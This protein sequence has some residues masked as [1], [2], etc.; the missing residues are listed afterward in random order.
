MQERRAEHREGCALQRVENTT[1]NYTMGS[2]CSLEMQYVGGLAA[3]SCFR[4]N[5]RNILLDSAPKFGHTLAGV[6]RRLCVRLAS[7]TEKSDGAIILIRNKCITSAS[8]L[9]LGTSPPHCVTTLCRINPCRDLQE[10]LF[11]EDE[12][13]IQC[14]SDC[15]G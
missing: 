11:L 12:K 10:V 2:L 5:Q 4:T 9:V 6:F 14:P 13:E 15:W 7:A 8:Y 1:A 3:N